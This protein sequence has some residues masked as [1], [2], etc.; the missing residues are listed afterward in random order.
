MPGLGGTQRTT[1]LAGRGVASE[2]IFT[3]DLIGAEEAARMGLVNRVVAPTQLMQTARQMAE[4]IASRAPVAIAK[5]KAAIL[6]AERLPLEEGLALEVDLASEVHATA[7]RVEGMRAFVEKR[8]RSLPGSKRV[9]ELP[10]K[11]SRLQASPLWGGKGFCH[12]QS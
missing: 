6:A 8:A 7:D 2:L 4:R 3:G 11:A 1:R 10:E 5:A 9:K 12:R